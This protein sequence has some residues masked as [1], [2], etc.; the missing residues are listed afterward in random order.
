MSTVLPTTTAPAT[1]VPVGRTRA[2]IVAVAI[3]L[4]SIAVAVLVLWR[5]GVP[6]NDFNYA[7]VAAVR[8]AV[9]ANNL[10]D[11]LGFAVAGVALALAVCML[12]RARGAAW[13]NVGAVLV[14]LC[15]MT[16]FA[17]EF[18]YGA[19]AWYATAT[20]VLPADTGAALMTYAQHNMGHLAGPLVPAFIGYNLGVLL[21]CVALWRSRAV[22]KW[23]P[24]AIAVLT[25]A[26]FAM[27][28][29]LLDVEEALTML[30]FIPVGWFLLRSTR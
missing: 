16:F 2:T 21:L 29:A 27:P 23:L 8:D 17:G 4:G 30:A 26:Q 20:A 7:D 12:A 11:G 24:I 5:P 3:A 18:A 13:A 9:W 15:G 28:A 14:S 6:R 10:V 1:T 22:P 25:V 19:F